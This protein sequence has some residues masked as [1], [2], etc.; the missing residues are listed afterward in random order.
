MAG[1]KEDSVWQYFIKKT[2]KNKL[3]CRAVCK[4]CKKEIQGLVQRLKKHHEICCVK[5]M[6]TLE[7]INKGKY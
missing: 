6:S 4:Y 3:G 2:E 1:R 7:K 5:Q